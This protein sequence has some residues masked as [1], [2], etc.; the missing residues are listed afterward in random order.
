MTERNLIKG[1]IP[2][3]TCREFLPLETTR[4]GCYRIPAVI[5]RQPLQS[6]TL[7]KPEYYSGRGQQLF[8]PA[9]LTVEFAGRRQ[10]VA[11]VS[12]EFSIGTRNELLYNDGKNMHRISNFHVK[13]ESRLNIIRPNYTAEKIRLCIK[14]QNKEI[15]WD[16][17]KAEWS[18]FYE[19]LRKE[20]PEFHLFL[21]YGNAKRIFQMY[22]DELYA[23][24]VDEV[25]MMDFYEM[26]GWIEEHGH[27]HY[28]SGSDANCSST[29]CLTRVQSIDEASELWH[30]AQ[31][32][33]NLGSMTT[34][35]PLFLQAHIGYALPFFEKVGHPIQY[36]LALIGPTGSKKT[37]LAKVL[38]CLFDIENVVNFT[39]TDRGI[40]LYAMKCRDAVAVL[41]DLNSAK[42][43]QLSTK[44]NRFLRQVG[45]SAG[46]AKSTNGGRDL[47]R[48][49]TR[50]AVVLTAENP[51]DFLQQSGQLRTLM[52]KIAPDTLDLE[53]LRFFQDDK[54]LTKIEKKASKLERYISAF[55]QFLETADQEILKKMLLF[56]PEAM[57]LSFD[58]QNEIYW[59][60]SCMAKLI[61]DFGVYVEA[62]SQEEAD[63]LYFNTWI[64]T[65]KLVM[66]ENELQNK[67]GDPVYMFL[68]AVSQLLATKQLVLAE[69]REVF[70]R[71]PTA[72]AGFRENEHMNFCPDV[73]YEEVCQYWSGLGYTLEIPSADLFS[74]LYK[75][76]ISEGYEQKGHAA[77]KLKIITAN[78]EKMKVLC[79]KW[80]NA[81]K[82]LAEHE[83]L[84]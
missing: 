80:E 6:F 41:D 72:Y 70:Q 49:D 34:V 25:K 44:L 83:T 81:K 24:S 38:F 21:E 46:R 73:V 14:N 66:S 26:V 82:Y 53:K 47:E 58:R 42:D 12:S 11:G 29:R 63:I 62:I 16:I 65:V 22:L 69:G 23:Q 60:L 43:S 35:L 8:I 10:L 76:N 48:V 50:F 32:I 51:L 54:C 28:V 52:V 71:Q 74:K 31:E 2:L 13:I 19:F 56:R 78:G 37:S 17:D 27:L 20:Y 1:R 79:L 59:A 61:V 30:Y 67:A 5:V 18:R 40:E 57:P 84:H 36:I 39:A 77:K 7:Q 68:E 15:M 3:K 9:S 55:V 75:Q 4:K 64:P 45:D 33:L